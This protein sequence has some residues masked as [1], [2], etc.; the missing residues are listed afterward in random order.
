MHI[1]NSENIYFYRFD[2]LVVQGNKKLLFPIPTE[3][4]VLYYIFDNKLYEIFHSFHCS[5]DQGRRDRMVKE[6]FIK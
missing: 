2:L 1:K 6:L 3:N 4:K 5:F